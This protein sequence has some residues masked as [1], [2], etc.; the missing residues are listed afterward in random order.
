MP[1]MPGALRAN[2]MRT[3]M[4]KPYFGANPR[5][6]EIFQRKNGW[7]FHSVHPGQTGQISSTLPKEMRTCL[8]VGGGNCCVVKENEARILCRTHLSL[9]WWMA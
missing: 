8:R 1:E 2:A 5:V 7:N 9:R 4:A 3:K 6:S